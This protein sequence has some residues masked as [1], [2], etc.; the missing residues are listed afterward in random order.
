MKRLVHNAMA[1]GK[2]CDLDDPVLSWVQ[3]S[4][5]NIHHH[6]ALQSLCGVQTIS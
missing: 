4:G 2:G 1:N 3:A 5:L 6:A